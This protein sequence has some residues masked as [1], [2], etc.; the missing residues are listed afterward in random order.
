MISGRLLATPGRRGRILSPSDLGISVRLVRFPKFRWNSIGLSTI[1]FLL[2]TC[3]LDTWYLLRKMNLKNL[4]GGIITVK[5]RFSDIFFICRNRH[6]IIRFWHVRTFTSRFC[7]SKSPWPIWSNLVCG[8]RVVGYVLSTSH[9]WGASA[10]AHVRI[11]FPYLRNG[12][13]HYA[14]IW[15]V[16]RDRS[17]TLYRGGQINQDKVMM[18]ITELPIYMRNW[19]WVS[20]MLEAFRSCCQLLVTR[21]SK[22]PPAVW[23]VATT[24]R[25]VLARDAIFRKMANRNETDTNEMATIKTKYQTNF[26]SAKNTNI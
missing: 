18:L 12:W 4:N 24:L 1:Y 2:N 21:G 17:Y 19:K 16:V 8:L 7:I 3:L 11:P 5:L 10:R 13:M 6:V 9:G 22:L 26:Y 15:W 25:R 14:E 20:V 23:P